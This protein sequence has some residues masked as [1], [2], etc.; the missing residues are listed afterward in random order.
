MDSADVDRL[1]ESYEELSVL[2]S[3]KQLKDAVLVIFAN[4]QVRIYI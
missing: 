3:E 4:K 2:M 1:E